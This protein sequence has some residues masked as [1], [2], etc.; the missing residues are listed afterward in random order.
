MGNTT[1]NKRRAAARLRAAGRST[2]CRRRQGAPQLAAQTLGLKPN[3]VRSRRKH[4]ELFH[5]PVQ[6]VKIQRRKWTRR[7][8][9]RQH[10]WSKMKLQKPFVYFASKFEADG[11]WIS[12]R[13]AEMHELQ[14]YMYCM[15]P[16]LLLLSNTEAASVWRWITP[17]LL[18]F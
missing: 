7:S 1:D 2:A 18:L 5:S 13:Q 6:D 15:W 16:L 17:Q 11:S 3:C 9:A 4:A 12:S 10:R 14:I 8:C